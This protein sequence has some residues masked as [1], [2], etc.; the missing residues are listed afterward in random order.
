MIS[1]ISKLANLNWIISFLSP[2]MVIL[3][4]VFWLYP[5][6]VWLGKWSRLIEHRPPLTLAS[7]V[8]LVGVSFLVTRFFRARRWSMLWIRGGIIACG[9]VA[10]FAVLRIEYSDGFGLWDGQWFGY[11]ARIILDSFITHP[12]VLAML[13]GAYLW[14]RGIHWGHSPL[15][16]NDVYRSFLN[17]LTALIGLVIIWGISLGFDSLLS[18]ASTLGLNVAGFFFF[19][20]MALSLG[21]LRGI[22]QRMLREGSVSMFGRGWLLIVFGVV[23]A[24]VL[25][26]AGITSIFSAE[27][28]SLLAGLI[29]AVLNLLRQAMYY[30]L[31]PLGYLAEGLVRVGQFLIEFVQNLF[32]G[33]PYPIS[34]NL[35]GLG[36]IPQA[37][38]TSSIPE[39]VIVSLKWAFFAIV[40][41]LAVFL[42]VKAVSRW[43]P[44]RTESGIEEIHESLWSWQGFKDDLGLFLG[45]LWQR[46]RRKKE[47]PASVGRLPDWYTGED[48]QGVLNI[49]EIYRHLLLEASFIGKKRRRQE[50][51]N[52]Y[53]RRL[54]RDLPEG[55]GQVGEITELYIDVRYGEHDVGARQVDHANSLWRKLRRL[56]RRDDEEPAE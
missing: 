45:T 6:F 34:T 52:E 14:W 41:A 3:M 16:F 22:Q 2:L 9:L 5:W 10:G 37:T 46:F 47:E 33:E 48:F 21:H 18:L 55:S 44:S 7:L 26:G 31:L 30:M 43:R 28:V 38:A 11:A 15:Y 56:L 42:L 13:A 36:D 20:L 54:G 50:T 40:A 29:T 17:G 51:P 1:I 24:I 25:L 4:E 27:F 32:D 35:T 49:R 23:A 8:F 53:A 19:G 39:V 12:I